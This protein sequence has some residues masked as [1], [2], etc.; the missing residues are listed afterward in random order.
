MSGP[1]DFA[2]INQA[3]W[4][5]ISTTYGS[6]AGNNTLGGVANQ[7][8]AAT[9][10]SPGIV[11]TMTAMMVG[12]GLE[13]DWRISAS[14]GGAFQI[15]DRVS[16]SPTD[17]NAAVSY[18]WPRYFGPAVLAASQTESSNKYADIAYKAERPAVPYQQSQGQ[19]KVDSVYQTVV[20]NGAGPGS[21]GTAQIQTQ[22]GGN[23][24]AAFAFLQPVLSFLGDLT[25]IR[26][27]RSLGW[28]AV[29][30]AF[31]ILGLVIWLR[32]PIESAV[33][34]IAKGGL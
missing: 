13:S 18:M 1:N 19:A 34:T 2:A 9:E 24:S 4:N 17:I 14:G 20:Q 10:S 16:F 31:L 11:D 21:T 15:T 8:G 28:I 25:D 7:I 29:G 12:A 22:V 30:I 3:I 26:V 33:G 32:K 6:G 27:W 23:V 5:Y